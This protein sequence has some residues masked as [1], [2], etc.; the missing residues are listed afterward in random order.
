M[1]NGP[2]TCVAQSVEQEEAEEKQAEAA[3]PEPK[4]KAM[5]RI[6]TIC[7]DPDVMQGLDPD[8]QTNKIKIWIRIRFKLDG[9]TQRRYILIEA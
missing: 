3:A 2:L 5:I 4:K 7:L 9:S 8:M 1:K 6:F